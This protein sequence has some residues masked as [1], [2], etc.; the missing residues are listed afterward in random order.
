[1]IFEIKIA[2][3]TAKLIFSND[4]ALKTPCDSGCN[5]APKSRKRR[6][7]RQTDSDNRI[8]SY[9]RVRKCPFQLCWSTKGFE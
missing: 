2:W 3:V 6:I 1:M 7:R 4:H 5:K 9:N 8:R